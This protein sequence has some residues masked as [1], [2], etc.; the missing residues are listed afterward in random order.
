[1]VSLVAP[2]EDFGGPRGAPR[3]PVAGDARPGDCGREAEADCAPPRAEPGRAAAADDAVCAV[4][5]E[6]PEDPRTG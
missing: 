3:T 1:M 2:T 4:K 5:E 6:R